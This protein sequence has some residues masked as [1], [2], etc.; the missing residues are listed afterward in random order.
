MTALFHR[1]SNDN[2]SFGKIDVGRYQ[3]IA[4]QFTIDTSATSTLQL[5]SLIMF[6]K[7]EEHNRLPQFKS[8]GQVIKTV[9]DE[10]GIVAVFHLGKDTGN[11][12]KNPK[13]AKAKSKKA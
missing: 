10:K 11:T 12:K 3:D 13:K 5:P 8:D 9:L 6:K 1:Y 4:E 2:F 7:G